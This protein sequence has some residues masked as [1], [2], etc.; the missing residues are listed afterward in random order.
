MN[1]KFTR[2]DNLVSFEKDEPFCH[3]FPVKRGEIESFE[4]QL[5]RIEDNPEL[6]RQQALWNTSRA[7]FIKEL[8]VTGTRANE[9]RWQKLYYRGLDAE[10]IEVKSADHR[11]KV[12]LK[13]FEE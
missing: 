7:D 1:W 11:T 8:A 6:M 9:D 2:P 13:P 3:F 12:R 4:P 10:G 5:R